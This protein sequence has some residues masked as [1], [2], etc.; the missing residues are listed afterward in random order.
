MPGTSTL[1]P[2]QAP[3]RAFFAQSSKAHGM[4]FRRLAPET[5]ALWAVSL[6]TDR[7]SRNRSISPRLMLERTAGIEPAS[8][9]WKADARPLGQARMN[10]WIA[11]ES[12]PVTPEGH[13][14]TVCC[15]HQCRP[16]SSP[17]RLPPLHPPGSPRSS[18]SLEGPGFPG[19]SRAVRCQRFSALPR[20][21]DVRAAHIKQWLHNK[22]RRLQHARPALTRFDVPASRVASLGWR[23]SRAIRR[24]PKSPAPSVGAARLAWIVRA[25]AG[26]GAGVRLRAA[27]VSAGRAQHHADRVHVGKA[28]RPTVV[29][30]AARLRTRR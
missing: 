6:R 18:S 12:N 28:H 8:T 16:Q 26:V 29:A 27:L 5:R 23:Q 7:G 21:F 1:H 3:A 25:G 30:L 10:W 20:R 22:G 9:A 4:C 24:F 2:G 13:R 17:S 11:R 14:F 15:G 19:S